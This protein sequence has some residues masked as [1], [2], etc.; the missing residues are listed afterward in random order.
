MGLQPWYK[1]YFFSLFLPHFTGKLIKGGKY[2]REETIKGR[3]LVSIK[4][5]KGRKLF[6]GG[7]YMR[8][9]TI[10]GNTVRLIVDFLLLDYYQCDAHCSKMALK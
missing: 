5:L 7:N 6:K 4:A 8:A 3:K 9:D 10:Q 2:S 1:K